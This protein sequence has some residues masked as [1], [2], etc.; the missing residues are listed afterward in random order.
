M[1]GLVRTMTAANLNS[2]ASFSLFQVINASNE[3]SFWEGATLFMPAPQNSDTPLPEPPNGK[4]AAP[5][6]PYIERVERSRKPRGDV[7]AFAAKDCANHASRF[8]PFEAD[9]NTYQGGSTPAGDECR[10]VQIG[11]PIVVHFEKGD[12]A[13]NI[14]GDP[15]AAVW[16]EIIPMI[17]GALLF[18]PIIIWRCCRWRGTLLRWTAP[19]KAKLLTFCLLPPPRR[20]FPPEFRRL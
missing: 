14:G 12:P 8:Y 10:D 16:N 20:R 11:A 3:P 5:Q 2:A 13:N 7:G 4:G 17:L 1:A 15:V 6:Y 18:P 19:G 9:G